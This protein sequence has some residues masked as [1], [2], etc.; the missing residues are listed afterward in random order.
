MINFQQVSK[1]FPT[2]QIA[3]EEIDV[4]IPDGDFIFIVGPSGAGKSTL[5]KLLTR[6][7]LPTTGTIFYNKEDI[8]KIPAKKIPQLRR[9]IGTVFQDFKLLLNRTV[10]ENVALPLEVLGRSDAEIEKI[11]SVT[12]DKVG[13]L[14]KAESFPLQ[15]SGGEIQRTAIARAIVSSPEVLLA[16]EPTGDLD[17]KTAKEIVELLNQINSELKTT[18]LMA[19]HNMTIVDHFKKRI[20]ELDNGKLVKDH[21]TTKTHETN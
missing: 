14:D 1:K 11:V 6:E 3:L 18:I 2:G 17:P 7:I 12:L 4:E 15:L 19:T 20:L 5:L 16:D 8:F 9:K 21:K 13:I 10:F